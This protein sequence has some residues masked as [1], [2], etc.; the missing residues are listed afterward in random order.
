MK[1]LKVLIPVC[2]LVAFLAI[3]AVA[4][5]NDPPDVEVDIS[6]SGGDV[7]VDMGIDGNNVD[8]TVDG[9]DIR[10]EIEGLHSGVAKATRVDGSGGINTGDWYKYWSKEITPFIIAIR[11]LRGNLDL[12]TEGVAKLIKEKAGSDAKLELTMAVVDEHGKT[13]N[14]DVKHLEADLL[15][16]EWD[17]FLTQTSIDT[18]G[19]ELDSRATALEDR[20]ILLEL[21]LAKD[22]AHISVLKIWCF[23]LSLALIALIIVLGLNMWLRRTERR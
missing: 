12:T 4:L 19:V 21:E 3:P 7:D 22:Q 13:L 8:V 1:W 10:N 17:I 5:A 23:I 15:N 20:V 16:Q 2:L 11:N 9:M 14:N 18:L 6:I